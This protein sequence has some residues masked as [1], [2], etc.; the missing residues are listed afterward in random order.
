MVQYS[1]ELLQ[2]C[3]AYNLE[4]Q[5]VILCFALASGAPAPDTY[6]IIYHIKPGISNEECETRCNSM[7]TQHPGM[8]IIINR[9]KN[10]QNPATFKKQQRDDLLQAEQQQQAITEGEKD[11][12]KTREGLIKKIIDNVLLSSGK[13]AISGLQTLAKLQGLD[14]PDEQPEDERRKYVLRWLS[15]CRSCKLMQLFMEIQDRDQAKTN[16]FT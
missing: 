13:D 10:K 11:E 8:K 9:I 16:D 7:L 3:K 15:A 12:L 6:R 14:H 1:A 4:A 2:I 5:D